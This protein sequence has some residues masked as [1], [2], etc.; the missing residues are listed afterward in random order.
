[1]ANI[2]NNFEILALSI[3]KLMLAMQ[4]AFFSATNY[5]ELEE[6]TLIY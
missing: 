5:F 6:I 4:W 1:M 3:R 2:D